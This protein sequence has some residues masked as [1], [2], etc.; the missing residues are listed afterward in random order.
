M[1]RKK[2]LILIISSCLVAIFAVLTILCLVGAAGATD[3]AKIN[4]AEIR[5]GAL[6]KTGDTFAFSLSEDGK[7][8]VNGI[9]KNGQNVFSV[10][11]PS[12]VSMI[13][14][15]GDKF[16]VGSNRKLFILSADGE[17][18][19]EMRLNFDA[20]TMDVN[21]DSDFAVVVA[22]YAV[23]DHHVYFFAMNDGLLNP[24]GD[25]TVKKAIVQVSAAEKGVF[26]IGTGTQV[27][28]AAEN[29]S[30][31]YVTQKVFSPENGFSGLY[32]KDGRFYL[33][34]NTGALE[35]Y[36]EGENGYSVIKSVKYGQGGSTIESN[37][38]GVLVLTD[39]LGSS[40]VYS[41]KEDGKI[42][43][44]KT[45][46]S[47]TGKS[48][49]DGGE[50]AV[51]KSLSETAFFLVEKL[52]L[53]SFCNG[54]KVFL[55][56][57]DCAVI[58]F[59]ALSLLT[60]FKK[61]KERFSLALVKINKNK[62]VYLYLLPVFAL[63]LL[64]CYYPIVW[65]LTLSFQNYMPG[66]RQDFVAFE[67]FTELF[68]NTEFWR[69]F[70]NMTIFLVG[71]IL[72][73]LI[74]PVLVAETLHALIS[75][76]TQY[77]ARFVMYIP[78]ILPGVAATLLWKDG[79]LGTDGVISQLFGSLGIEKFSQWAWLGNSSTAKWALLFMGFPWVGQYL[80]YYGALSSV[81]SSLYEAADLE[82]CSWFKR[83]V[84]IDLPMIAAQIKYVLVTTF[85]GSV[86][87]FSRVYL[88]TNGAFDTNIPSLEL[89]NSITK[90]QNYGAAATMGFI[91]FAIIFVISFRQLKGN[92][93]EN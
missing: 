14:S 64:F 76:K 89:Y 5:T 22:K 53:Y 78:G 83:I 65:G 9:D 21:A 80:I 88:T 2:N 57:T 29:G 82:G 73:A 12:S 8:Y 25:I 43:E 45:L 59:F 85:I 42:A 91:L 93:K 92:F 10:N 38:K 75:K 74:P 87:N 70:G 20:V 19:S 66:I 69:S 23:N 4:G 60:S 79:I 13:R 68:R 62:I 55:V 35:I 30:G 72:K 48:V 31:E 84:Y 81:P 39:Y 41:V 58:M 90:H 52:P 33:A 61:G 86:Q 34:D 26:Y 63:L 56:I 40:L 51:I 7:Y 15:Y 50:I 36:K 6:L 3:R 17:I 32:Y 1:K 49:N 24:I 46:T 44:F 27:L 16:Y 47:S 28:K 18:L 54:V 11:M 71:D 37:S 67:N 77:W